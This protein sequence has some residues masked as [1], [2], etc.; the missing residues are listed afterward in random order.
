MFDT[1]NVYENTCKIIRTVTAATFSDSEELL[2]VD[3][4]SSM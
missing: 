2:P 4:T 1:K 3:R